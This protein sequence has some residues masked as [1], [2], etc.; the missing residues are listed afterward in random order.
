M[1]HSKTGNLQGKTGPA[2]LL[3]AFLK[4]FEAPCFCMLYFFALMLTIQTDTDV[5]IDPDKLL[6][7]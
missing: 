7:Y 2:V 5:I 1:F 3:N 6:F 4:H